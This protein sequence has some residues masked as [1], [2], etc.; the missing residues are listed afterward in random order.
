MNR[1]L[2]L[3]DLA[4]VAVVA[5]GLWRLRGDLRRARDRYLILQPVS[6]TPLKGPLVE[7]GAPPGVQPSAYIDAA[8]NFLFNADR[9]PNVVVEAHPVKPRPALP[10]LYGLM[11]LGSGPIA[12]MAA[13]PSAAHK[14]VRVGEAIGEFKLLAAAGDKITLEWEG[15]KIDAQISDVLVKPAAEQGG[16][17]PA[18]VAPAAPSGGAN[19]INPNAGRGEFLIG[20][21]MQGSSGTVYASPPGDTAP[22]GTVYQNKRKVVRQTPFG[23]QAWWEDVKQ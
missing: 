5:A 8:Q 23:N 21:P 11:N 12:I 14:T 16:G 3:L 13:A 19:V 1:R 17:G 6:A 18:A 10:Q 20:A 7:A 15:Q 2:L 9:N 4:L 22:A